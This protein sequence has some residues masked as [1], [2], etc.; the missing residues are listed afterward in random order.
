MPT[1]E[2]T[3]D[4]RARID[5]VLADNSFLADLGPLFADAGHELAIVGGPVRDAVLGRPG[6][7]WDFATSAKPDEIEQIVGAWADAVWDVGRE[8]GTI[9]LRKGKHQ[10][11]ITTYR[12]DAYDAAVPQA[13]G[14]IRRQP[15][16]RPVAPRLRGQ[17]DGD[18]AAVGVSSS[19]CSVGSTTSKPA[20]CARR[21]RPSSRSATIRCG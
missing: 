15:R 4:R 10:L 19:T 11:E 21:S 13:R 16:R 6:N 20:R 9:G 7:D 2:L 3:P 18:P 12:S 14:A 8:F 1:S 17:R 5:A